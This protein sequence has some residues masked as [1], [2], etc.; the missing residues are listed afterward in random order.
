MWNNA[1]VC[2][3]KCVIYAEMFTRSSPH[4]GEG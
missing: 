1:G 4:I 2:E 3:K